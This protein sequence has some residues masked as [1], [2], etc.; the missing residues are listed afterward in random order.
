MTARDFYQKYPFI[1]ATENFDASLRA[2]VSAMTKEQIFEAVFDCYDFQNDNF[3]I[4]RVASF[5]TKLRYEAT[6]KCEPDEYGD[7]LDK[8][9]VYLTLKAD[10]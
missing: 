2:T 10:Q 6:L 8:I 7:Y 4:N 9:S 1:Q 3:M 5:L